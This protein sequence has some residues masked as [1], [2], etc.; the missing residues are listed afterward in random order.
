MKKQHVVTLAACFLLIVFGSEFVYAQ[1]KSLYERLGGYDEIAAVTDDFIG[2]LATDPTESRFFVGHSDD[3]KQRIRQHIVDQLCQVTGGP[4]VYKGRDMKTAHK[5]LGITQAD[6]DISV[7]HLVAT[8]D[9]FK[10]PEKEKNEVLT[11]VSG[12]KDQIVEK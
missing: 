8:L 1:Q 11:A 10:V 7:K 3:S 4:C 5:G 6:W 9:K 2:R 12:L